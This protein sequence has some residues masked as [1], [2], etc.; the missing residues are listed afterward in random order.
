MDGT[1]TP[2]DLGMGMSGNPTDVVLVSPLALESGEVQISIKNPDYRMMWKGFVTLTP[3][4]DPT[5]VIE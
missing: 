4:A 3:V 2:E 1:K 5:P